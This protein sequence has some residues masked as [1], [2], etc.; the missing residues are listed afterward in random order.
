[1]KPRGARTSSLVFV[2]LGFVL[3]CSGQQGGAGARPSLLESSQPLVEAVTPGYWRYHP[4]RPAELNAR[5]DLA[6]GGQLFVGDGGERWLLDADGRNAEPAGSLAPEALT[7]ALQRDGQWIFVSPSGAT[8]RADSPLGEFVN[9][10][11]PAMPLALAATGKSNIAGVRMDGQLVVSSDAG[12]GYA[13]VG[14]E[15]ARFVAVLLAPPY[16]VALQVPERLWWS[17]DEGLSWKP[18]SVPAFGARGFARDGDQPIVLGTL[19]ARR[20]ELG[21]APSL[22]PL[23]RGLEPKSLALRG[24]PSLGPSADA[25]ATGRAFS[26]DGRY[27]ELVPGPK[28]KILSGE[29]ARPLAARSAPEL[30]G[31]SDAKVA[32][33]GAWVYV[34]CTKHTTTSTRIYEF[35][36][37]EDA[38]LHF[39]LEPYVAR[40]NPEKLELAVGAGGALLVSGVCA[41]GVMVP[42]CNT[43]GL[44]RRARLD[45]DAGA[46]L[47]LELV[48]TPALDGD[49]LAM[50]FSS[51]GRTAYVIGQRSKSDGLFVFVGASDAQRFDP[52]P[53]A[54]LEHV[55][56]P[57]PTS[58][59]A[60]S[61]ARDG[62]VSLVLSHPSGPRWLLVLDADGRSLTLNA[63]PVANAAVAA[64]GT[65]ALA[66]GQDEAWESMD[67]GA[68]WQSLGRVPSDVCKLARRRCVTNVFCQADGCTL[69]TTLTRVGWKGQRQSAGALLAPAPRAGS[70]RQRATATG[71]SCDLG[72]NEWQPLAGVQSA[73]SAAQAAI[74]RA[75][76]FALASDDA[77]ASAS[78]W[79]ASHGERVQVM[80]SPLLSESPRAADVAYYPA[81]QVEGAAALRYR[82]AS[83]RGTAQARLLDVEVSWD[84]LLEGGGVRRAHI[85]DAGP[86]V[87]GDFVTSR[88]GMH[89]AKPDLLSISSGGIY[90]RPHSAPGHEQTTYFLDGRSQSTVPPLAWSASLAKAARSE[91]ARAD[92]ESLPLLLLE[93]GSRVVRARRAGERWQLSAMTLGFEHPERFDVVQNKDIGYLGADAGLSLITRFADG[94][95]DGLF[96]P[97]RADGDV[98]GAPV[99]IATQQNLGDLARPCHAPE[100]KNLPR[101][102]A[103]YHPGRRRPIVIRDAVDPERLFLTATAVVHGSPDSACA[104]AFDAEPVRSAARTEPLPERALIGVS[105]DSRS[106]LFRIAPDSTPYSPV[107]EYRPMSCRYDAELV[108]PQELYAMPGTLID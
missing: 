14:P 75:E 48:P 52:Q 6:D 33:H 42:S 40:G 54:Q 20:V 86:L 73:P 100:R 91:M 56:G 64:Y 98:L 70:G 12:L 11:A 104:A 106:W 85:D 59:D 107:I 50:T 82:V 92:G 60:L 28:A 43:Q 81:L 32:G 77:T 10:S 102:V 72:A 58:V 71:F 47:G 84:N 46:T 26:E 67:G 101:V 15:G 18:L 35:L 4:R 68:D 27:F 80:R 29:L 19:E 13:E 45:A 37:S 93:G 23:A 44:Q 2:A 105:P 41:P 24:E 39:E 94:T 31:C 3:S 51:D 1:M 97:F 30:E 99:P 87:S 61:A 53:L 65:R 95:G 5:Y 34:A 63:P 9:A 108:P 38:G 7:G 78:M 36:R 69:G 89:R 8:Y 57:R 74:G 25:V 21:A 88:A 90:V 62:H 96:F 83:E 17:A 22:V 55:E 66:L 16:G 103:P 79:L 49:A 76:W